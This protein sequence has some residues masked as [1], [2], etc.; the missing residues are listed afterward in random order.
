[1]NAGTFV[2]EAQVWARALCRAES[3]FPGDYGPAM[4]RLARK[5]GI[6]FG[7]IWN[8]HYRVPKSIAAHDY[9]NLGAYY[10]EQERRYRAMRGSIEAGTP[11]GRAL[12]TMADRLDCQDGGAVT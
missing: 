7:L 6:S 11:L 3:R 10:L 5:T 9:V 4:R 8:L 12:L 1:M 2:H